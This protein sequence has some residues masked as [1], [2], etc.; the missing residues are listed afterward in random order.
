[1][2]TIDRQKVVLKADDIREHP[3]DVLPLG[4]SR[5]I[6][7]IADADVTAALGLIGNSLA[8]PSTAYVSR[9]TD[10]AADSRFEFWNHGFDHVLNH[11]REDGSRY[12]EFHNTS[13]EHQHHHLS[14]TQRLAKD[15][16]GLTLTTFGAPGN[17]IDD[18]TLPAVDEDPDLTT[19]LYG[20]PRSKKRI[21]ERTINVEHPVHHP[22]FE[23]FSASYRADIPLMTLQ[24]HPSGW[25]DRKFENFRSIVSFLKEHDC[26]F[27]NPHFV[28]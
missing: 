12:S 16:L 22:D 21:L 23:A 20:D 7:Y 14:E 10:L 2:T 3:K 9:L 25:D 13:F 1:M 17:H 5:F 4:W 15:R 27:T 18:N 19:W 24:L 28:V 8:G 26:L 11:K 6:D